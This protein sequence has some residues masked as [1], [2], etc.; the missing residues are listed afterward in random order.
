[1]VKNNLTSKHEVVNKVNNRMFS[2]VRNVS[3]P[4]YVSSDNLH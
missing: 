3:L 2:K 4:A 1:V